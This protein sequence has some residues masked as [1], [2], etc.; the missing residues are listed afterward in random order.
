MLQLFADFSIWRSELDENAGLMSFIYEFIN[1][2]YD[3]HIYP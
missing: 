1:V 3:C 2:W